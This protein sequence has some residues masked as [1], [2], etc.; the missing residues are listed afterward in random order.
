MEMEGAENARHSGKFSEAGEKGAQEQ[1]AGNKSS[2]G[3]R[4]QILQG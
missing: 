4:S 2:K 3:G 1:V